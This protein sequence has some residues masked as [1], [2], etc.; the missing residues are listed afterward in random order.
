MFVAVNAINSQMVQPQLSYVPLQPFLH[1]HTPLYECERV[2]LP[3]RLPAFCLSICRFA[4]VVVTVV[5]AR[6]GEERH[7]V[8]LNER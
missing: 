2:L 4:V 6:M 8:L 5:Y 3:G 7:Q 1:P